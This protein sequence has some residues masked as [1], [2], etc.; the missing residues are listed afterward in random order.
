L[1]IFTHEVAES[2]FQKA[3]ANIRELATV[4]GVRSIIR[5]HI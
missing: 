4:V 5:T 2:A 3:I 1:V